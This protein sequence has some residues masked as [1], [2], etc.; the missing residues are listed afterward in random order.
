M[1]D[2][3]KLQYKALVAA[4]AMT[5]GVDSTSEEMFNVS[6]PLETTLNQKIQESIEFLSMINVL[7]HSDLKGQALELG[8]DGL[9]ARRTNVD[10]D[11]RTGTELGAPNGST[12]EM[13]EMEYDVFIKYKTM[14]TWASLGNLRQLYM[15]TVYR[16][17]G[18]DRMT[19][20]WH[21]ISA[22][23]ES[24]PVA[25]PLGQDL[26]KGW[27]QI[28]RDQAP[29]QVMAEGN[30]TGSGKIFVG[31]NEN[32]LDYQNLDAF[33][34]DLYDQIPVEQ[35]TGNEVVIVGSA[36]VAADRNKV[37]N[38]HA[39]TPSEKSVGITTLEKSYGGLTAIQVPR[40]PAT[41]VFVGDLKHL[42][43]Y[44]QEGTVRRQT[45]DVARRKRVVDY[46]SANE[47][48]AIGNMKAV[49]YVEP[50]AVVIVDE[51]TTAGTFPAPV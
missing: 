29:D 4:M 35:R 38:A 26:N 17:I 2:K 11:D 19:I 22:A 3:T 36:L 21:G 40:F 43:I 13:S 42:H 28:L 51:K 49:V 1:K 30:H 14:D 23:A 47:C 33:V 10:N 25:N 34:A 6:E 24:D 7:P 27:P 32:N 15:N 16:G 20:G 37:L 31:P 18:L 41:G 45:E 5:Y 48:Y 12:W 9:L 46:V 50:D 8:I 39:Q 44:F